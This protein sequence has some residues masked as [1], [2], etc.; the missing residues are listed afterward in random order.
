[1]GCWGKVI[2]SRFGRVRVRSRIT[3]LLVKGSIPCMTM[4]S[5]QQKITTYACV[6]NLWWI[7]IIFIWSKNSWTEPEGRTG[8]S[9]NIRIYTVD[10]WNYWRLRLHCTPDTYVTERHGHDCAHFDWDFQATWHTSIVR[11]ARIDSFSDLLCL[12]SLVLISKM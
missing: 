10:I 8:S 9:R 2:F 7:M 1:M 12:V 6:M 11:L 3:C 4:D 5:S